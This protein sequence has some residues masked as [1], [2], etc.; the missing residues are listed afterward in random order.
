MGLRFLTWNLNHRARAKPIPSILTDVIVS[1]EPDA[2]VLTEYVHGA[3]RRPFLDQLADRGLPNWLVS[4]VTPSKE[5]HVLIASRTPIELGSIRAPAI[6]PSVPSNFLH[7]ILPQEGCEILGLRV[8]DFSKQRTIQRTCW[9]WIIETATTVRDRPFVIMGDFN[10]DPR[11]RRTMCGDCIGRLSDE[12]WQHA[13]PIE[14]A[15]YWTLKHKLPCRID[16]A[17]VSQHFTILDSR[18]VSDLG[19]QGFIGT[20]KDA[21]SD[22]AILWIDVERTV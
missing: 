8:P 6:S 5:N 10:T 11:Y 21:L 4:H 17:F 9:D 12:G 13:S 7:V 14:G 20:T 19:E 3:S 2:V 15:S 16:H 18:Y 1:L 22:H